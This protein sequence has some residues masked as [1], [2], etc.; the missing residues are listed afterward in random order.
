[1]KWMSIALAASMAA[2]VATPSLAAEWPHVRP[3]SA[4]AKST[5]SNWTNDA[6]LI[7]AVREQNSRNA[8]LSQIEIDALDQQ[9]RAERQQDGQPLIDEVLSRPLS[10]M[11]QQLQEQSDG[12]VT[13]VFVMDDRGLNVGQSQVTSDYWQGDEAKW[14][15]TFLVGPDAMLIGDIEYDEST[16][17]WQSQLSLPITDPENG[18]VIGAITV[19]IDLMAMERITGCPITDP[20]CS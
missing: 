7:V 8:G 15:E 2:V 5:V 11:L 12:I 18:A 1:M 10:V 3:V 6:A 16:R 9:W 4:F 19:G 13:E 20:D 17:K 14:Q